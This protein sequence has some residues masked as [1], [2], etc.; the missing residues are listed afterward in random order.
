[1]NASSEPNKGHRKPSSGPS[2]LRKKEKK[3]KPVKTA[4][5]N[6]KAFAPASAKNADR[7]GRRNQE[8]LQKKLHVPAVD[9]TTENPPPVIVAVVGPPGTGKTTLIK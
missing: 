1:M 6:P 4:N 3:I 8:L 7:K 2:A 5:S 9:R